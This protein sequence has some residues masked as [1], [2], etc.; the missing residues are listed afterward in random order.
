MIRTTERPPKARAHAARKRTRSGPKLKRTQTPALAA[1]PL[2]AR[3]R[4][5][6]QLAAHDFACPG[7]A[8]CLGLSQETVRTHFAHIYS[9]LGVRSRG[10]AVAEAMRL[11][12]II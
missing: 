9:K 1:R 8:I 4:E 10:G 5:V 11:G 6:L 12:L 3:E 2:T 7:I